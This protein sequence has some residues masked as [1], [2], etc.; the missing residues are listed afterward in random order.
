M[1]MFWRQAMIIGRC[2]FL[3]YY[4]ILSFF[5]EWNSQIKLY[6]YTNLFLYTKYNLNLS[7]LKFLITFKAFEAYYPNVMLMTSHKSKIKTDSI[8]AT[9]VLIKNCEPVPKFK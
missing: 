7:S 5:L 8:T 2:K 9:Y 6:F 4:T 3:S 1:I